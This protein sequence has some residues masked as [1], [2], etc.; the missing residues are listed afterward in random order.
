MTSAPRF[1]VRDIALYERDTPFRKPFRFGAVTVDGASQAFVRVEIALED[2]RVSSGATAE[3]MV[4][5]WFDKNPALS[6]AET[7]DE[8]RRSLAIA[9]DIYLGGNES[10]AAFALHAAAIGPQTERCAAEHIPAL[11]AAFGP[12]QI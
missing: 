10:H 5:K 6:T 11:A 8:L 3:L 12:A 2:G 7:V 4:P 9:R 1:T